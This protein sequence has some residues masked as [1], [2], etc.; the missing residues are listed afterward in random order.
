MQR[1]GLSDEQVGSRR[2]LGAYGDNPGLAGAG[3]QEAESPVRQISR[4]GHG[5]SGDSPLSEEDGTSARGRA[6]T[7]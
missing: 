2:V 6:G 1:Q 4:K 7:S 5:D 3:G